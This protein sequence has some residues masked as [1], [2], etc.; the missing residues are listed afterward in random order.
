MPVRVCCSGEIGGEEVLLF[1][2]DDG[3]VYQLDK[4]T[5]FDGEEIEA[6]IRLP[7]NHLQSPETK[8]RFFKAV[9]EVDAPSAATLQW[10]EEYDYGALAGRQ[11]TVDVSLGGGYWDVAKWDEFVWDG[12]VVGS[13]TAYMCG[14]GQ[15]VSIFIRSAATYE[16]PHTLQGIILHYSLRGLSR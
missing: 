9:L 15:N 7:F 8:K 3:Y 4:G 6:M 2:S 13:A 14:S 10:Q 11:T 1:G 12:T 5:S 16:S